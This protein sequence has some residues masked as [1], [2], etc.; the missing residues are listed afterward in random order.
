MSFCTELGKRM[1]GSVAD[2][3]SRTR[4]WR[5]R[6]KQLMDVQDGA[7]ATVF[8]AQGELPDE[9]R[10]ALLDIDIRDPKVQG[11]HLMWDAEA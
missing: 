8:E 3:V 2:W 6:P 1:G 11:K 4:V 10:L 9:A 5:V 7:H